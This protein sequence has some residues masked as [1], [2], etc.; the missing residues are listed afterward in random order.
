M[1]TPAAIRLGPRAIAVAMVAGAGMARA[2]YAGGQG[3]GYFSKGLGNV[4]INGSVVASPAYFASTAGGDGYA[5]AGRGN[6]ALNGVSLPAAVFKSSPTGGDGYDSAGRI[7]LALSGPALPAAVFAGGGS[8]AD[9]YDSRGVANQ[10]L[11]GSAA[12]ADAYTGSAAGGDGY[13]VRG[14]IDGPLDINLAYHFIFSG[15]SGDGYDEKGVVF[16]TLSGTASDPAP[17]YSSAAGGDGYDT[18]GVL[19]NRL[20]GIGLPPEV[21]VSSTAGGDG[22]DVKGTS[23]VNLSGA[24]AVLVSYLGSSGDGFDEAPLRTVLL[25]PSL[26]PPS[27]VFAGG[28]GDGYDTKPVP[29]VY[30]FGDGGAAAPMTYAIWRNA[31]FTGQE[32]TAGLAADGADADGDGLSNIIEYVTGGDPR[33]ADANV[34]GPQFRV[35]DL[36]DF[37]RPALPDK[38]LT[39]VIHRDPRIFDATLSVEFSSDTVSLWNSADAVTVNAVSS[40]VIVR[41]RLGVQEAPRRLL[42]LRATIQP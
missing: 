22:Y 28:P 19:N 35:S 9:G 41:D 23:F 2:Q 21:Y 20:D 26:A 39:A 8:G 11:N 38:H 24:P 14:L 34:F 40:L 12:L 42:R 29:Y 18:L 25:D 36:T 10:S 16:A 13:D 33:I 15:G 30:Y 32:I 31:N 4:Y 37:G 27:F 17:Y 7:L 6:V 3:D 1:L 5:V